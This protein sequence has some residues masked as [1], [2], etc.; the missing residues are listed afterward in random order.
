MYLTLMLLQSTAFKHSDKRCRSEN[1]EKML[2]LAALMCQA[3]SLTRHLALPALRIASTSE[4]NCINITRPLL[5]L[6]MKDIAAVIPQ[7]LQL[8]K[9][10]TLAS[11]GSFHNSR[12]GAKSCVRKSACL[13]NQSGGSDSNQLP[14]CD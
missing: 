2:K 14:S 4:I 9:Q 5:L 12:E 7:S 8:Q 6:V 1:H 11:V 10:V 13:C 3:K